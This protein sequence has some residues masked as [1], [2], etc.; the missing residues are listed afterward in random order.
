MWSK[1]KLKI[2]NVQFF[3]KFF[4]VMPVISKKYIGY[5]ISDGFLYYELSYKLHYQKKGLATE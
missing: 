1:V 5:I 2:I 4:E 3:F